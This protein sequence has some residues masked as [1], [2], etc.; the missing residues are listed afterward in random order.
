M[1]LRYLSILLLYFNACSQ[2][3]NAPIVLVNVS[4][5]ARIEVSKAIT[6]INSQNPKVISIDLQFLSNKDYDSDLALVKALWHC[7]NL[8]MASVIE[9]SIGRY[10][11]DSANYQFVYGSLPE[12][13]PLNAKTGFIN[14]LSD[15]D[16]QPDLTKFSCYEYVE[17]KLEYQFSVQTAL[18]ID[19]IKTYSFLKKNSKIVSLKY[20][21]IKGIE[22]IEMRD[23]ITGKT[24]LNFIKGKIV[25]IGYLGPSD[26][27]KFFSPLNKNNRTNPDLYGIEYL[28]YI[29][30]MIINN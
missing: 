2:E 21:A 7:D 1:K 27:D 23:I 25:L 19:S 9:D 22:K 29:I 4:N 6:I 26:T 12:F 14:I 30:H 15:N 20:G 18:M 16:G 5:L 13:V 17:G 3:I 10:N 8:V 11:G 24:Q 28:A